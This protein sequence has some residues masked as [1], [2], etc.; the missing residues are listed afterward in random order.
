M[1]HLGILILKLTFKVFFHVFSSPKPNT[2]IDYSTR[3]PDAERVLCVGAPWALCETVELSAPLPEEV[4]VDTLTPLTH[5]ITRRHCTIKFLSA[6]LSLSL[7]DAF[8]I[9]QIFQL[10]GPHLDF[11]QN[12]FHKA[13]R[14]RTFLLSKNSVHS[15]WSSL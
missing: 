14:C 6:L 1:L 9:L 7:R 3:H 15:E 2:R 10:L 5:D 13:R 8:Q 12:P 4:T 11:I